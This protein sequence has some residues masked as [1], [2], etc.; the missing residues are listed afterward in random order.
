VRM[1]LNERRG[2]ESESR[3]IGR[4]SPVRVWLGSEHLASRSNSFLWIDGSPVDFAH[5]AP[6]HPNCADSDVLCALAMHIDGRWT[7]IAV[8][9]LSSADQLNSTIDSYSPH[10]LTDALDSINR[11]DAMPP[12]SSKGVPVLSSQ[13]CQR[14]LDRNAIHRPTLRSAAERERVERQKQMRQV[15]VRL[16]RGLISLQSTIDL[17]KMAATSTNQS[18]RRE[19]GLRVREHERL[20]LLLGNQTQNFGNSL[21]KISAEQRQLST[22][23]RALAIVCAALIGALAVAAICA[24]RSYLRLRRTYI[25]PHAVGALLDL[26]SQLSVAA[27]AAVNK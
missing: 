18:I 8:T 22:Q 24:C 27:A 16:D 9:H 7:D 21:A 17:I 23:L 26:N 2:S 12:P 10:N 11:T 14:S 4:R 1:L 3:S 20:R 19:T 15:N 13:I 5:W 6:R 25:H